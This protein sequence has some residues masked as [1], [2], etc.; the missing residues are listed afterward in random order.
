VFAARTPFWIG[1][2]FV[3]GPGGSDEESGTAIDDGTGFELAVDGEPVDLHTDL[4]TEA[5]CT[6]GKFS[7]AVFPSGLPAGWHRFSGR[8]Y[9]GGALVLTSDTSIE[10]VE[11]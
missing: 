2:G 7:V 3:A 10:F 9:D 1:Y 11:R 8:W 4:T 6:T 5:G